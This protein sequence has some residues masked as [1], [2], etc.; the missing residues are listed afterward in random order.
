MDQITALRVFVRV[1]E[2]GSF[3]N[4]A[5]ALG[6]SKSAVSKHVAALE[7]KLGTR[8]LH[9]TTR[10][11]TLTEEGR[12]YWTRASRILEEVEEADNAVGTM[13]A[14]PIGTLRVSSAFSFGLRHVA[15]AIPDFI[16]QYPRLVVDLD[17]NDRMLDLLEDGIDVAIRIGD[18]PD[19]NLVAR[20]LAATRLMLVA[21]P[22]YLERAGKPMAP[23]D[24]ARHTC[25]LYRGRTGP[26]HWRL[27][28]AGGGT[29][30]RVNGPLIANNGEVIKAA[31][32]AGAGIARLPSFLLDDALESGALV[33]VLDAYRPDPLPIHAVYVPNRHLSAKVRRFVDF[34]AE[35]LACRRPH[36]R[37]GAFR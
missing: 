4:A 26:W 22:G 5:R 12:A 2:E 15:P 9:R 11:V 21:A 20:R 8:L 19:S 30:I 16:A 29:T 24:L 32:V 35:W 33:E 1:A 23:A 17:F 36:E 28:G 25:L 34:L 6:M 27:G 37:T 3:S 14:E 13:K 10:Q 18:L 31:A 7:A